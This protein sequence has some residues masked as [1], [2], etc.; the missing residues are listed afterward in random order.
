MSRPMTFFKFQQSAAIFILS[1]SLSAV[2]TLAQTTTQTANAQTPPNPAALAPVNGKV[3]EDIVARVNDQII[4]QSDYD[5]AAEQLDQESKQQAIPP[6]ELQ[7]KQADLLRDQIDQQ[8][9]LSK[10]KELGI[11]GETELIKRLDEIR[12]QN[13]LD[14]LE[15]LEKAAQQQ[16]VSYEDFKANIR[17][18]IITQQV[19]RDEVGRHISMSPAD[20][21][22]YFKQHE[23]EFAQPESVTLNEILIPTPAPAGGEGADAAQVAAAQAQAEAIEAKLAAGAKF[24]DLAKP[25]PTDPTAPKSVTLGEYRR[26]MLAKEIEDKAF[27]LNAGQ[28]TQPIRT[29]QGFI[30]LQASQHQLGGDA[31]FKQIEPQVEEALFL[32]RMQPA[33]RVYLTKLREEAYIELKPGAVDTGASGNEMRLTYSAYTPPAEKKKKKFART[34]FRGRQNS[35]PAP[36][37]TQ[38]AAA[39][40]SGA[41]TPGPTTAGPTAAGTAT[42]GATTPSAATPGA[43]TAGATTTGAKTAGGSTATTQ[44]ASNSDQNVQKPGKKEKIRFGQAPRESLPSSQVAT[45]NVPAVGPDTNPSVTTP[46]TRYVNPDGTVSGATAS[47]PDRKTRLSNRPPVKK[48]KKNKSG[49]DSDTD[50][51]SQP[52]PEELAAQKVQNAPLGLADQ[53][54]AQKKA[55]AKGEKTRYADKPKEPDQTPAPY[56]G[57][58]ANADTQPPAPPTSQPA[59]A[60][61]PPGA[62]PPT[63]QQP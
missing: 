26:G 57:K 56:L 59:P 27:A 3:V 50:T 6:R 32:E 16:G 28:Y 36:A 18:S 45:A 39:Q 24:E 2:P 7:Q 4:T 55:K 29:K 25:A 62:T 8:L 53:T 5:R 51:S 20:V 44:Q 17:N 61:G 21:Q 58:P 37:T 48:V 42:A 63:G 14:S 49:S 52:T 34:R 12:K 31:S 11:T 40:N 9:L 1:A 35:T 46:E 23:S 15:D 47:E 38:T 60:T 43:A 13:H 41:A 54:A 19:V 10:G 33:L 30:I 22:S